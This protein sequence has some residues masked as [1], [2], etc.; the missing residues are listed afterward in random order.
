MLGGVAGKGQQQHTGGGGVG[1]EPSLAGC[2]RGG[3]P[4]RGSEVWE[5]Q[6]LPTFPGAR[7]ADDLNEVWYLFLAILFLKNGSILFKLHTPKTW[8]HTF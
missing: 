6:S 8:T 3:L 7:A 1:M 5:K 4:Q 2:W